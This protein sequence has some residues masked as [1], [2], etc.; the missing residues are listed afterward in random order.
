MHKIIVWFFQLVSVAIILPPGVAKLFSDP[1]AV[2]VF[3]RLGME[4]FGRLLVG[5][6]EILSGLFLLTNY[7]AVLG[8][9]IAFCIM[10]GA[11]LAHVTILGYAGVM[12][13]VPMILLIAVLLISTCL[14]ML[15]RKH[16][17]PFLPK[18]ND[19]N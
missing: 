15:L 3:M 17:L 18:K 12:H 1:E 16:E 4:P 9:I 11:I 14:V 6:L 5:F 10:L 2:D 8:A 19:M 7:F 13:D